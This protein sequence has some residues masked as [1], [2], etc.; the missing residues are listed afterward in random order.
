MW[1]HP[2]PW[3]SWNHGCTRR[4]I[5]S[6]F[7]WAHMSSNV[8]QIP[9][10]IFL[11]TCRGFPIG[12]LSYVYAEGCPRVLNGMQCA[13]RVMTIVE[14]RML[15]TSA[16]LHGS[17]LLRGHYQSSQY[18]TPFYNLPSQNKSFFLLPFLQLSYRHDAYQ[19]QCSSLRPLWL[20]TARWGRNPILPIGRKQ[21][22]CIQGV[23]V[24]SWQGVAHGPLKNVNFKKLIWLFIYSAP[25][26]S[27]S[28]N[29]Y[30]LLLKGTQAR[31]FFGLWIWNLYFFVVSY[32]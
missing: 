22:I 29:T 10:N 11:A 13:V 27:F 15:Y 25:V 8:N 14:Y 28:T 26:H 5:S 24:D 17:S 2:F 1:P 23:W 31:E 4:L 7:D 16:G 3:P 32:A 6:R 20:L 21:G 12:L 9:A 30:S 19:D 18:E